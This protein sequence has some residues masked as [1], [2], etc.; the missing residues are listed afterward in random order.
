MVVETIEEGGMPVVF[1]IA[2]Q[3][4]RMAQWE[5]WKLAN[6]DYV[7]DCH[8]NNVPDWHNYVADCHN[9]DVPEWHNYGGRL[10][11]RGRWPS[12]TPTTIT[13]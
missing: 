4:K 8:N 13:L 7:A 3:R 1:P 5:L 9:N 11:P 2:P 10:P 6:G 12:K